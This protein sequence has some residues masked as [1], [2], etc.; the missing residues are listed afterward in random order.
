MNRYQT[1]P[2]G[3]FPANAFGLHDVH[4]NVREWTQDCWNGNY[5]GAPSDGSAWATWDCR[6]R[7][8]RGG[9]WREPSF[10]SRSGFRISAHKHSTENIAGFRVARDLTPDIAP[11]PALP[12]PET[13]TKLSGD[14]EEGVAGAALSEPFVVEVRDQNG[15]PLAEAAVTF[16]VT[17]GGGTLS[18]TTARTDAD[19]LAS[20]TLTLGRTPGIVTVVATVGKLEHVTF[21]ASAKATPDFDGDG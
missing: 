14:E 21:T 9:S 10:F 6:D 15:N 12:H 1:V 20:T 8:L 2:V 13:L 11:P 5:E 7:V 4:G 19:G 17:S 16:E 18:A 3:S